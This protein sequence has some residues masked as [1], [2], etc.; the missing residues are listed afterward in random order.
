MQSKFIPLARAV[1]ARFGIGGLKYALDLCGY[2]GGA[3]RAPLG[4]PDEQAQREIRRI[5]EEY[6]RLEEPTV[7]IEA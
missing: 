6:N 4:M 5:V 2:A 3:V 1:T 7:E